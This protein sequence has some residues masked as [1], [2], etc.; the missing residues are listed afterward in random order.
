MSLLAQ[1]AGAAINAPS[2]SVLDDPTELDAFTRWEKEGDDKR[3]AESSLRIAG[4]HCAACAV[5]IE[6]TLNQVPGVLDAR[7][8]AA[9][10]CA[11]RTVAVTTDP[12]PAVATA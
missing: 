9:S 2:S 4:M 7:V 12:T 6:Q 3:V 5:T 1:T 10:Q 11:T 8:S